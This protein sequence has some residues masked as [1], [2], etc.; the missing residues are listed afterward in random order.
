MAL[1]GNYSVIAKSCGRWRSGPSIS[2]NRPC[3]GTSGSQRGR[4]GNDQKRQIQKFT[5]VPQG[6]K[7]PYTW[8]IAQSTGGL[9]S[10]VFIQGVGNTNNPNL[11]PGKNTSAALTASGGLTNAS[12]ALIVSGIAALVG[13]GTLTNANL[14]LIMNAHAGLAG[15]G[16]MVSAVRA[17]GN[18]LAAVHGNSSISPNILAKAAISAGIIVT[19]DTVTIANVGDLV[20]AAIAEGTYEYGDIMRILASAAAGLASGGPGSPNF[21][22]ISDP[23]LSRIDGTADSNGNRLTVTLDPTP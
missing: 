10:N 15:S 8:L 18:A 4:F 12:L 22:A 23:T 16:S 2:Q 20:W 17:L 6:Y 19:A 9:G 13:S 21:K 7:P 14:H 11:V 5:S 3:W 1:I